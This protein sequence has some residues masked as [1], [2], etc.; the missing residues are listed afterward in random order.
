[1]TVGYIRKLDKGKRTQIGKTG[2]ICNREERNCEDD[3]D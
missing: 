1:M 2:K 3:G